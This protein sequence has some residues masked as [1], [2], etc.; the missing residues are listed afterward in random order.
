[1]PAA[2]AG[3]AQSFPGCPPFPASSSESSE[4]GHAGEQR[5]GLSKSRRLASNSPHTPGSLE[6]W[7][8]RG[9]ITAPRHQARLQH[10]APASSGS[11]ALGLLLRGCTPSSA[12]GTARAPSAF[13]RPGDPRTHLPA[14][15]R[16][17]EPLELAQAV[18]DA[19]A[20]ALLQ[21]RLQALR[22]HGWAQK[23]RSAVS[24]PGT[25]PPRAI[26][27]S[28]LTQLGCIPFPAR[29]PHDLRV[30]G[31]LAKGTRCRPKP[32]RARRKRAERREPAPQPGFKEPDSAAPPRPAF[33]PA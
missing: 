23:P 15:Q 22:A 17:D 20:P 33:V 31:S 18:V 3:S 12:L 4:P 6:T 27:G 19:R 10:R 5:Q 24:R 14:Q 11:R 25:G 32:R 13:S 16:Q 9:G 21:Q 2:P 8:S 28:Y 26:P 30:S 1:M 29:Q 7:T